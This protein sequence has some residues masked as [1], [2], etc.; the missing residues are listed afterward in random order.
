MIL[1]TARTA[2]AWVWPGTHDSPF[3]TIAFLAGPPVI[4][5][6]G[7]IIYGYASEYQELASEFNR[8]RM[9]HRNQERRGIDA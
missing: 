5:F 2:L 7:F 6:L 8:A 3:V 4:V 9:S 1:V